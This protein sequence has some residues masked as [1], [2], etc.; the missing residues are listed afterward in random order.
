M[1]FSY[2]HDRRK[3]ARA[4][5]AAPGWTIAMAASTAPFKT[6]LAAFMR[7]RCTEGVR[8]LH[9]WLRYRSQRAML[10]RLDDEMLRDIGLYR[11][12]IDWVARQLAQ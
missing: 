10:S 9:R 11:C 1:S 3:P 12:E 7:R 8:A 5:A 6:R 4:V 2:R